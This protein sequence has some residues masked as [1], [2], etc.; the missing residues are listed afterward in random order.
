MSCLLLPLPKAE[1]AVMRETSSLS[2]QITVFVSS[3]AP[4]YTANTF[5]RQ[6]LITLEKVNKVLQKCLHKSGLT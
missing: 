2:I 5:F 6:A 4:A 3:A 1:D